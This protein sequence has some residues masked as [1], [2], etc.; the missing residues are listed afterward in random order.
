MRSLRTSLIISHILPVLLVAPLVTVILLYLLETQ[1]LLGE[2]SENISEKANLIAQTVN[3]RPDLLQN[4]PDAASFVSGLS[5]II[6]EGVVLLGPDGDIV[7]AQESVSGD[8]LTTLNPG[9]IAET[10]AAGE[11]NMLITYGLTQQR[12]IVLVPVKDINDQL[13]GIVG[14]SDTLSGAA[15]QVRR[16][17]SLIL[18]GLLLQLLA[19]GL[20]GALLARRLA[21]PI[22]GAATAVIDIAHGQPG[23]PI[24]AAGPREIQELSAAVNTLTERLRL[25]EETRRRSLANI[26]HELGRPLG[27]I[28]TAIYVLLHGA[29]DDPQVRDELLGGIDQTISNMEPLLDDLSQLHGQV[30]GATQINRRPI[31]LGEWL[32]P[33]LLPWRAVAL[34]KG[35]LWQTEIPSDL[36][37]LDMDPDRMA[38]VLGNLISNAIKYTP[39]G[40]KVTVTAGGDE[41][42]VALAVCDTGPGI[43]PAEQERVFEPFYRS[44]QQRRFPQGLG[45]GLTIARD[46]VTAHGGTLTLDSTPGQGSCFT[47][48]LP[49]LAP[50]ETRALP[51]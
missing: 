35:L 13:I 26:V 42:A 49:R 47:I 27:A 6:D 28:R 4:N 1:I 29:G 9:S 46:L 23:E 11:E 16:L 44:Q 43:D 31:S 20:I 30:L 39:E 8:A 34:E 15:E 14:V 32:L 40:G 7:A 38:Q 12:A 36:P 51:G 19:G 2:M 24:P 10:M 17:R 25:L 37:T 50:P 18:G 41:T 48:T 33:L 22:E 21:Q 3:G 5:I 45:L